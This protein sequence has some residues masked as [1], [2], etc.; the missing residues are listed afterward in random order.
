M[1]DN[2]V[3]YEDE[4]DSSL[5]KSKS[6]NNDIE[7]LKIKKD[8]I[9]EYDF[10]LNISKSSDFHIKKRFILNSD[11]IEQITHNNSSL[12]YNTNIINENEE[13]NCWNFN[14][15][16][17]KFLMLTIKIINKIIIKVLNIIIIFI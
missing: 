10:N 17:S 7:K 13:I 15:S 9:N 2:I 14:M 3:S 5:K 11:E 16:Q 1:K 4:K 12:N 8:I 6:D